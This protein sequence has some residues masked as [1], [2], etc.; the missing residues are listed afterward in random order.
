LGAEVGAPIVASV[1]VHSERIA[2]SRT[3][4]EVGVR[5][6]SVI[7]LSGPGGLPTQ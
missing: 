1:T 4:G 6:G 3:L 7:V 5:G 2:P